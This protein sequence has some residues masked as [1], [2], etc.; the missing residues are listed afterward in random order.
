M[1]HS[2]LF[3]AGLILLF[4]YV[5]IDSIVPN[6]DMILAM[7]V[8]QAA[9][10]GV[11]CYIYWPDALAAIRNRQP[12]MG[13]YLTLGIF[14]GWLATHCQALYS[15]MF[16]LAGSPMWLINAD[17]IGVWISISVMAGILHVLA[18]EAIGGVV[19][20]RNRVAVGSGL[21]IAIAVVLLVLVLRP[22][23]GAAVEKLRP[24]IS[25]VFNTGVLEG[26]VSEQHS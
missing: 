3:W 12:T 15:I 6:A 10:A 7:R 5:A 1:I 26:L 14:F 21:G 20:R 19:P 25:D 8:L 16:R 17:P 13:D 11:V 9:I 22:D 4:G 2:R 23:L 18:P 24:F